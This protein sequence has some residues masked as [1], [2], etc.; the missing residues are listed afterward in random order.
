M[1]T[2]AIIQARLTS[3]RF[4]KKVLQEIGDKTVLQHVIDNVRKAKGIDEVVVATPHPIPF[5]RAKAYVYPGDENDVL[6][7]YYLAATFFKADTIIRITADCPLI[8]P[9]I[10]NAAL[11]M[12]KNIWQSYIIIAPFSGWDVEVFSYRLLEEANENAKDSY[13]RE[14]VTPYMKRIMD[15]SVNTPEELEKIRKLYASQSSC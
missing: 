2:V 9:Q 12:Y 3:T 4:P 13:D 15:I 11:A 7:R 1:K 6:A 8:N 10:I 14:H 5:E